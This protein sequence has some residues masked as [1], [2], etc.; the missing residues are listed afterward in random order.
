MKEI[1]VW[2][3]V[4]RMSRQI[5][6][7]IKMMVLNWATNLQPDDLSQEIKTSICC[8]DMTPQIAPKGWIKWD[9]KPHCAVINHDLPDSYILK[10]SIGGSVQKSL[11]FS[12]ATDGQWALK[13]GGA[14]Q[15]FNWLGTKLWLW[16]HY[17]NLLFVFVS[18]KRL[19]RLDIIKNSW[20]YMQQ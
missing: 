7:K 6:A 20:F 9:I 3:H 10:S 16:L 17:I 5:V 18:L 8:Q 2:M 19:E 13:I 14:S 15:F 1:H 11:C 12:G 4:F